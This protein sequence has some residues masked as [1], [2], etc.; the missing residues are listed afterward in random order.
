[1][2]VALCAPPAALGIAQGASIGA[3]SQVQG[4]QAG[5]Q[6]LSVQTT[7][8]SPGPVTV[9]LGGTVT[10]GN[11]F[12][13]GPNQTVLWTTLA[14]PTPGLADLR[15][16]QGAL[17]IIKPAAFTVL[18][19]QVLSVSPPAGAWYQG[20]LLTIQGANFST[21]LP[22]TVR[23]FGED[24]LPAQVQNAS[25]LTVQI[26]AESI[27]GAGPLDLLVTQNGVSAA[28]SAAFKSL[29][30]LSLS[31][32]GS[33]AAGGRLL[34]QVESVQSGIAFALFSTNLSPTPLVLP[35]IHFGYELNLFNSFNLGTGGLLVQPTLQVD[36]PPLQ[37]PPGSVFQAQALVVEVGQLGT[38]NSFT[39]AVP[40]VLP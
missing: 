32:T 28:L 23:F 8:F 9:R 34:Y 11:V 33:A 27:Q 12:G 37:V 20:L 40:L 39:N 18:A 31:I 1:M 10:L 35:G 6:S 14:F 3:L 2:S 24:P 36:Y 26:P 17:D 22:A 29:P 25:T 19:P 4:P 7:G 15:L 16:T 5:G 30:A 38:W 21:S 13:V